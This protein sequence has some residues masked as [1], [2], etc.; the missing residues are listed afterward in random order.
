MKIF[1]Y[2]TKFILVMVMMT[3]LCTWAWDAFLNGKVYF[4][5]DGG[6][7]DYWFRGDWVHA[8]DGHPI[9]IVAKIIPRS[10]MNAPDTIKQGWGITKLWC[11]WFSFLSVSVLVSAL[12]AWKRWL[13]ILTTHDESPQ[14][15]AVVP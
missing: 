5:T 6:A 14:P 10:D 15:S 11:M 8:H 3:I 7:W 2:V 12:L 13:P 1:K 9:T 4:C